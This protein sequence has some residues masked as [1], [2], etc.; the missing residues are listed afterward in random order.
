[1]ADFASLVVFLTSHIISPITFTHPTI[2]APVRKRSGGSVKSIKFLLNLS[3]LCL[4]DTL[5]PSVT[6]AK[7]LALVSLL[8]SPYL[9]ES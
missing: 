5:I 1:M 3:P 9:S 8:I 6:R 4:G 7:S 2:I